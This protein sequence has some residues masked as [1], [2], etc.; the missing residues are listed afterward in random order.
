MNKKFN[1]KTVLVTGG[2]G[3]IG[4]VLVRLLLNND[5]NVIVADNLR[6]GGESLLSIWHQPNFKF[7]KGD[8]TSEKFIKSIFE[9]NKIDAVVHLA[10]IVGDLACANNPELARAVNWEASLKLLNYAIDNRVK[11]FISAST[12]SN[13]GK[14]SDP[15]GYVD[16]KS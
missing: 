1:N 2:A 16:E 5:N 7:V 15:D 4:S 8:V 9:D 10:A 3:Y 11:R 12:C 6:F 14:M 13:Y